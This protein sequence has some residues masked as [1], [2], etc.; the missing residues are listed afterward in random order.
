MSP[1]STPARVG[2][3]WKIGLKV[4]EI[5]A[6]NG[7]NAEVMEWELQNPLDGLG[8]GSIMYVSAKDDYWGY[9][10]GMGGRRLIPLDELIEKSDALVEMGTD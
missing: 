10:T 1:G 8:P 3:C 5:L 2:Q 9:P 4:L 7:L 6:F